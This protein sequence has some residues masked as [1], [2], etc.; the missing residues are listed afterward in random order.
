MQCEQ[1]DVESIGERRELG[2]DRSG[3]TVDEDALSVH[4]DGCMDAPLGVPD[5]PVVVV[6]GICR[7][8]AELTGAAVR[9]D[10]LLITN[11]LAGDPGSRDDLAVAERAI[12]EPHEPEARQVGERRA[13]PAL[14]DREPHVVEHDLRVVLGADDRP[15]A[16]GEEIRVRHSAGT[17]E[18]PAEDV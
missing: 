3:R 13:D 14:D 4:A 9:V 1:I 5:P 2:D 12:L 15:D 18:D 16:R 10:Q 6:E 11:E 7:R 17:L 8:P